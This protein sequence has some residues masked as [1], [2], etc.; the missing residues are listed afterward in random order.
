MI[1][2]H[3]TWALVLA[4]PAIAWLVVLRSGVAAG[5][6]A[7]PGQWPQVIDLPLQ[8]MLSRQLPPAKRDWQRLLAFGCWMLL[9]AA[10]SRPF[11]Q[12]EGLAPIANLAGRVLVIDLG[13]D[14]ALSE[15]KIAATELL[16]RTDI[17]TAIVAATD[18]AYTAVPLTLDHRQIERN[19]RVLDREIMPSGGRSLAL[20]F[21]HAE[22]MLAASG[23][24]AGQV[25]VLTGG[26]APESTPA[27]PSARFL[28][29]VVAADGA[30]DPWTDTATVLGAEL[31]GPADLETLNAALDAEIAE[32]RDEQEG[33]NRIE[34]AIWFVLAAMVLWLGLFRREESQ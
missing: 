28:R 15:Q 29:G 31:A 11:I 20:G 5:I 16:K 14:A 23:V 30:L 22:N 19:L 33:E 25:I 18:D 8:R 21:A 26:T 6:A 12:T 3:N 2:L 10:I 17:P 24:L 34:L 7:L 4:L 27:G 13:G 9:V 1:G 32:R